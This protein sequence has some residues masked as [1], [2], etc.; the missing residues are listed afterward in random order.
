MYI[1]DHLSIIVSLQNVL[2]IK[3]VKY[4]LICTVA[5]YN[6]LYLST[7]CIYKERIDT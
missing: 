5:C 4:K 2:Y 6:M 3:I 1:Q 7:S